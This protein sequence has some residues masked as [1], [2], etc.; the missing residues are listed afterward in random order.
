MIRVFYLS[1]TWVGSYAT[2][3]QLLL[4]IHQAHSPNSKCTRQHEEGEPEQNHLSR[5]ILRPLILIDRRT[6]LEKC[7]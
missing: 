4:G 7:E 5:H 2:I 6:S 3:F 1:L